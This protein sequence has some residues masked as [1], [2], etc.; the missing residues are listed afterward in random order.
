MNVKSEF[1]QPS[2]NSNDE[3]SFG[4]GGIR[5]LTFDTMDHTTV[6]HQQIEMV[7]ARVWEY[8]KVL[9]HDGSFNKT[10]AKQMGFVMTYKS[11][12]VEVVETMTPQ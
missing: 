4:Q 9:N 8:V 5:K 10:L 12:D 1:I 11:V 3:Q 6:G 7:N 2:S